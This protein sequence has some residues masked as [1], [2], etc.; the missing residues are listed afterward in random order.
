MKITV[1]DALGFGGLVDGRLIAGA[2]G[3]D[4]IIESVTVLEVVEPDVKKWNLPNQLHITAFYAIRDDKDAQ[5]TMIRSLKEGNCS[6]LVVCHREYFLKEIHPELIQ[7]CNNLDFPLI[8]VPPTVTYIEILVPIVNRILEISNEKNRLAL[9]VQEELLRKVVNEEGLDSI[10]RFLGEK[11]G[12]VVVIVDVMDKVVTSYQGDDQEVEE[13][14]GA[15]ALS[16]DLFFAGDVFVTLDL[17]KHYYV[18]PI[19]NE[20]NRYGYLVCEVNNLDQDY[21]LLLLKHTAVACSLLVTQRQRKSRMEQMYR[22]EFIKE[23]VEG[24]FKKSAGLE[25]IA[26]G[27]HWSLEELERILVM[28]INA[29]ELPDA[30]ILRTIDHMCIRMELPREYGVVQGR[31]L[32]F[33]EPGAD[34]ELVARLLHERVCTYHAGLRPEEVSIA[35][36]SRIQEL[37]DIPDVY[38]TAID[39][40]LL[41]NRFLSLEHIYSCDKLAFLPALY[42][43]AAQSNYQKIAHSLLEPLLKYDREHSHDMVKTLEALLL[44]DQNMQK[45]AEGLFIHRNTLQYRRK[46]IIALLG[47]DPFTGLNRIN[48][49]LAV[50]TIK[51]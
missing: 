18:Y 3:L 26:A 23:L 14:R 11:L 29:H 34:A 19:V 42:E 38:K 4:N 36:S 20:E 27:I 8:V 10:S 40:L 21:V 48:Y 49:L 6:G 31:F 43:N 46:Q 37:E 5:I 28:E 1:R 17:E 47:E 22:N 2:S 25:K 44:H 30:D 39:T 7:V 9:E 32:L 51:F 13:I 50:F 24:K 45:I 33:L 35:V 16:R 15:L 41:G 12:S